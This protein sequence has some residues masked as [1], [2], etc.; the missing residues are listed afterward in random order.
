M[1][2]YKG[3][4]GVIEVDPEAGVIH[5]RVIGLRDMITFEAESAAD[6]R[7]EFEASV[8]DYLAM[9]AEAGKAPEKPYSG[10]FLVR[11]TPEVHRRLALTALAR[12][13]SLNE[14]VNRLIG[15]GGSE[16][17]GQDGLDDEV[18]SSAATGPVRAE[19]RASVESSD[20]L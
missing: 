11:T 9:C 1:M 8:D 17:D 5:G 4:V 18:Q 2:Q 19:S 6:L 10:R 13:Q 16:A 14:L 20:T 12:G 15:G 3:Y 7:K